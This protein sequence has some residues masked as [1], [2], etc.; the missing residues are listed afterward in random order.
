MSNLKILEAVADIAYTAGHEKYTS[1][2]SRQDVF[3]FIWWAEQFEEIHL[4]TNWH[5]EDYMQKID[6]F[7]GQKIREAI[8]DTPR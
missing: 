4:N 6:E 8:Q 5:Q 2:D 7:A 1:G 3:N